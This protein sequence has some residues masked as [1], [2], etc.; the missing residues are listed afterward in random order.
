MYVSAGAPLRLEW[1]WLVLTLR[2]RC[3][4]RSSEHSGNAHYFLQG[5]PPSDEGAS[6]GHIW[7]PWLA[8]LSQ[9]GSREMNS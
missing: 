5:V 9:E 1:T 8:T 3:A 4:Q 6:V 2:G 7:R